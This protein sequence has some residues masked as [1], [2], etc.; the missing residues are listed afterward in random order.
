MDGARA[1]CR[2]ADTQGL[3]PHRRWTSGTVTLRTGWP[4]RRV[5]ARATYSSRRP[6]FLFSARAVSA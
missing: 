4:S 5:E 1:F 6:A 2:R 3:R